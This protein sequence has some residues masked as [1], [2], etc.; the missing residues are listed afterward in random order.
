MSQVPARLETRIEEKEREFELLDQVYP[1]ALARL[2]GR[3]PEWERKK[4]EIV[5]RIS[6]SV[7]SYK[8]EDPPHKAVAIIA[9]IQGDCREFIQP[10]RIV[11]TW[12]EVKRELSFLHQ[13]L[14]RQQDSVQRVEQAYSAEKARWGRRA[15]G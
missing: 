9:Q 5:E 10:Q 4:K 12:R 3:D 14:T 6:R 1:H 2:E 7:L 15:T 11:D 8:F 13:E